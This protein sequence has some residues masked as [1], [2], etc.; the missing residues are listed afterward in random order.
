MAGGKRGPGGQG[1]SDSQRRPCPFPFPGSRTWYLAR[2]P[3]HQQPAP[4]GH[5]QE[6]PTPGGSCSKQERRRAACSWV[7][8]GGSQ[9]GRREEA[10]FLKPSQPSKTDRQIDSWQEATWGAQLLQ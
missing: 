4:R 1:T 9:E 7:C 2:V 5:R 6:A 3:G 10:G 8:V